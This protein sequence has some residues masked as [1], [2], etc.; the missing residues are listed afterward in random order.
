MQGCVCWTWRTV[1]ISL[2]KVQKWGGG[3]LCFVRCVDPF[4]RRLAKGGEDKANICLHRVFTCSARQKGFLSWVLCFV[5]CG[6][7]LQSDAGYFYCFVKLF[8]CFSIGRVYQT[9]V[10]SLGRG[11]GG[12][13]FRYP[14][15]R[16]VHWIHVPISLLKSLRQH[17][18]ILL[19]ATLVILIF[20]A[21]PES[22]TLC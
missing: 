10:W 7:V 21:V 17:M 6:K 19:G 20:F 3:Y 11:C 22:W 13:L 4:M 18:W 14:M 1:A 5:L 15:C 16:D 8:V 9:L 2:R 12:I